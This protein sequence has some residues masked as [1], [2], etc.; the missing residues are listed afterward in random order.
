MAPSTSVT[1]D[2]DAI[3]RNTK[4]SCFNRRVIFLDSDGTDADDA[5]IDIGLSLTSLKFE[6]WLVQTFAVVDVDGVRCF[7]GKLLLS[8]NVK[9]NV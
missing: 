7:G 6:Y 3:P 5:D 4:Q 8:K 2:R 9:N 1:I